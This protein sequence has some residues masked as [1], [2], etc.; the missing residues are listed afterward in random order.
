MVDWNRIEQVV[1]MTRWEVYIIRR[2]RLLRAPSHKPHATEL[3]PVRDGMWE[4]YEGGSNGATCWVLGQR[5]IMVVHT[6]YVHVCLFSFYLFEDVCCHSQNILNFQLDLNHIHITSRQSIHKSN[7]LFS[8]QISNYNSLLLH[9]YFIFHVY[10]F[11][12][13]CLVVI[14]RL[15]K[16]KIILKCSKCYLKS[17][18]TKN[19]GK[20]T[21]ISFHKMLKH[22]Y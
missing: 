7:T 21:I 18:F 20:T 8:I 13:D 3:K 19:I 22:P 12:I 6:V 2:G 4:C 9:V 15:A 1:V 10:L 11:S 5:R 17:D 16:F 14:I